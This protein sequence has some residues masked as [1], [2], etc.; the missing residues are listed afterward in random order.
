MPHVSCICTSTRISGALVSLG[1]AL[2]G[3]LIILKIFKVRND[4]WTETNIFRIS[5]QICLICKTDW[6][7]FLS[8]ISI[9]GIYGRVYS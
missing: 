4:C 7:D 8:A 9:V 6:D 5:M 3:S 2:Q 1:G